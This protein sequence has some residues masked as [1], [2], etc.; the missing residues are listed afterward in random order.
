M[1][2]IIDAE[3]LLEAVAK[4][5]GLRVDDAEHCAFCNGLLHSESI[6]RS[7]QSRLSEF[8]V[9]VPEAGDAVKKLCESQKNL[10][11]LQSIQPGNFAVCESLLR[12]ETVMRQAA[13]L[14]LSQAGQIEGL[15]KD[16]EERL[17][18]KQM[19][20][21]SLMLEYCP[22]DMTEEQVANWAINQKAVCGHCMGT[23]KVYATDGTG[24][25]E[26][27]QGCA[28]IDA[29]SAEGESR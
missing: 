21:D 6:V 12:A 3:K 9:E 26:C 11:H 24:P 2:P 10:G 7:F 13:A 1:K 29:A 14:I 28:P 22:N 5:L 25:W 15:R 16:A 18:G 4:E 19:L 27:P 17:A 23:G 20:I 8:A